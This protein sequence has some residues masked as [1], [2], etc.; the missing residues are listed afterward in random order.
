MGKGLNEISKIL[1]ND[2]TILS[3]LECSIRTFVYRQVYRPGVMV[4]TNKKLI[5]KG[6]NLGDVDFIENFKYENISSIE[7][8]N[9]LLKKSIIFYID[10]ESIKLSDILSDNSHEFLNVVRSNITTNHNINL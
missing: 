9:G 6:L 10:G 2:E 8:K 5:F 4:A 7:E 3:S 1:E